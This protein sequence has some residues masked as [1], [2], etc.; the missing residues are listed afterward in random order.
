MTEMQE[1]SRK[2][3]SELPLFQSNEEAIRFFEEKYG[4]KFVF[5]ESSDGEDGIR[6]FYRLIIDEEAYIN[7]SADLNSTGY[8]GLEFK[9]SYQPIQ[10]KENGSVHIVRSAGGES[11]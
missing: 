5:E 11:Y 3:E 6:F 9:K 8:I 7:G 1:I 2:E 4:E 10:I